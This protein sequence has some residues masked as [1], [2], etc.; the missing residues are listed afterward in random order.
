MKKLK[1]IPLSVVVA[2]AA[3]CCDSGNFPLVI[4]R[5]GELP[6]GPFLSV[7]ATAIVCSAVFLGGLSA[8][9]LVGR[10]GLCWELPVVCFS[11][12]VLR[13]RVDAVGGFYHI[14]GGC[15]LAAIF[16]S[17][18]IGGILG[19]NRKEKGEILTS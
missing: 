13:R 18:C 12:V 3:G 5:A 19:V 11:R 15:R 7:V 6:R 1:G 10:R 16:F 4:A 8:S 17:G 2:T 9:L 14:G